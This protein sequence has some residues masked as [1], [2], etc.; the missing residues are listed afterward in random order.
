MTLPSPV[1]LQHLP[2]AWKQPDGRLPNR[3]ASQRA[4]VRR[5]L[6][7]ESIPGGARVR[8]RPTTLIIGLHCHPAVLG[9]R[10]RGCPMNSPQPSGSRREP[11]LPARAG[12]PRAR[13]R[14]RAAGPLQHPPDQVNSR[15]RVAG[16]GFLSPVKFQR[17][18]RRRAVSTTSTTTGTTLESPNS[19]KPRAPAR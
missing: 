19:M 5:L 17:M 2:C 15:H 18:R 4:R 7:Q 12:N 1:P 9:D 10:S 3:P 6:D 8:R 16:A 13:F 14:P 11:L